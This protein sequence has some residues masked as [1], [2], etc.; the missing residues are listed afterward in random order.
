VELR[1]LASGSSGNAYLVRDGREAILVD[2][3]I[4]ARRLEAM[5]WEEG[6]NP[7]SLRGI[8]LTHEHSDHARGVWQMT[9]RFG[10]PV[11]ASIGTFRALGSPPEIDWRRL[12][13]GRATSIGPIDVVPVNVP[14]DAEEPFVFRFESDHMCAAIATDFGSPTA[15][16]DEAFR[17]LDLLVLEAN[18]DED[19]L[20][21][22][23]Y[24]W[25][26]KK[27]VASD[28]GHISNVTAGQI[29]ARLGVRAPRQVWL[30]H[31]SQQNNAPAH[32]LQVVSK[33]LSRAGLGSVKLT[34]AERDR[35]SLRWSSNG[36]MRQLALL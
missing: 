23:S 31:L 6:L 22:G 30:A 5:L 25:S 17:D 29:I 15:A 9:V 18:H 36:V 20:W 16:L 34:V 11:Y 21:R 12:D 32:A 35:P 33:A 27:R 1:S 4:S 2:A 26:L 13:G 19:W 8:V 24:P 10:L 28:V 14:H 3:G 7:A